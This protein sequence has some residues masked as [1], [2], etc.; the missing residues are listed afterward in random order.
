[1]ECTQVYVR[2][3]F[4]RCTSDTSLSWIEGPNSLYNEQSDIGRSSIVVGDNTRDVETKCR[5]FRDVEQA[6]T[7]H[8]QELLNEINRASAGDII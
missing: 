8:C 7:T 2:L 1:M 5:T 6:S 4:G 3:D